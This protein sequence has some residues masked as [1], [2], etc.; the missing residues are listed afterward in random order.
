[1]P[2]RLRHFLWWVFVV[3][4]FIPV[5]LATLGR[6]LGDKLDPVIAKA[7]SWAFQELY[8]RPGRDDTT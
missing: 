3:V 6:M 5:A 8:W 4:M 1:M 2:K 7:R